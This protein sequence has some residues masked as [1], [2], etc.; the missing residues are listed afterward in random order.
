MSAL[1]SH[2]PSRAEVVRTRS[3][4][5]HSRFFSSSLKASPA[6]GFGFGASAPIF[7]AGG[8]E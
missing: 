4:T 3:L 5:G 6:G 1:K 8:V 2:R 7:A